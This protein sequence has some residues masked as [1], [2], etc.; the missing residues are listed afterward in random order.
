M[1][2][3]WNYLHS[4]IVYIKSYQT[5]IVVLITPQRNIKEE[6]VFLVIDFHSMNAPFLQTGWNVEHINVQWLDHL[7][8]VTTQDE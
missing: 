5:Y 7:S 3:T 4:Q 6:K 2:G 8:S 1:K